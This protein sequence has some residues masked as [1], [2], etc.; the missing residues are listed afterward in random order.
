VDDC[1]Q[2]AQAIRDMAKVVSQ[3]Q[4]SHPDLLP[5]VLVAMTR[6]GIRVQ[7]VPVR[8]FVAAVPTTEQQRLEGK[9]RL[10]ASDEHRLRLNGAAREADGFYS[11]FVIRR[12]SPAATAVALKLRVTPNQ[13]TLA[14]LAIA[15]AAMGAFSIGTR[16]WLIAGAVLLQ[17]SLVVD[18]V[19]GE[20]ARYTRM[21][22]PLGAWLDAGTD[23]FKEFG[24]YATL[25]VGAARGGDPVWLL[26]GS[27]L[28]LQ[29]ARHFV[30]FGF[31]LRQVDRLRALTA[32]VILPLDV[33]SDGCEIRPHTV[34]PGRA[35]RWGRAATV[36]S[37]RTNEVGAL[38]WLKRVIIM[39][40]GE[41]WLVLSLAAAMSGP[42]LAL[43]LLLAL[44]T[45]AALYTTTGRVLR[46][47]A[48]AAVV[49]T[50]RTT[51]GLKA[52]TDPGLL[53]GLLREGALAGRLGWLLPATSR[54]IE[55]GAT[56][57]AVSVVAR[58][59]LPLAFAYLFVLAMWHY[60]A[61]YRLRFTGQAPPLS[62]QR[63][64]LG[65][66]VRPVLVLTAATTMAAALPGVVAAMGLLVLIVTAV[67]STKAWRRWLNARKATFSVHRFDV[68]VAA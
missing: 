13:V 1:T 63:A 39:P 57:V 27:A 48:A 20:L 45:I 55:Y 52:L 64:A 19:D 51:S 2:A 22:S 56:L 12:L 33:A 60:D 10:E 3:Q 15:I 49:P 38:V 34:A 32:P 46:S 41:R 35:A 4:W 42:R 28:A 9:A 7:T 67:D 44:G 8:D 54:A 68:E 17:L 24:I 37:E 58:A 47:A 40:I 23:R 25:A 62:A 30:D 43:T 53:A 21:H 61:V 14:S 29:V 11:S 18:C 36:L 16:G 50:P 26:A 65:A 6:S 5:F 31:A 66:V 59:W